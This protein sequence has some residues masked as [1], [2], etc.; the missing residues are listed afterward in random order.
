MTLSVFSFLQVCQK[1]RHRSLQRR[2]QKYTMRNISNAPFQSFWDSFPSQF[3]FFDEVTERGK[4]RNIRRLFGAPPSL[5]L[6]CAGE[7]QR[8][9]RKEPPAL[10]RKEEREREQ[11][12]VFAGAAAI[13]GQSPPFPFLSFP[14]RLV[15]SLSLPSSPDSMDR[16][17]IKQSLNTI[18]LPSLPPPF[19]S[20]S[21]WCLGRALV[22]ATGRRE[23][24]REESML[25]FSPTR[26]VLMELITRI[27]RW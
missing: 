7:N 6:L 14:F 3:H 8:R 27:P 13:P 20:G 19:F 22:S 18:L 12:L 10:Q 25:P 15:C 11:R 21:I 17:S 23:R 16:I 5:R 9:G 26:N 4:R 1:S 2:K 24:R